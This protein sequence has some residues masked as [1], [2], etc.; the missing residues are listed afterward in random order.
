MH[1]TEIL[2]SSFIILQVEIN[3][4]VGGISHW[5]LCLCPHYLIFSDVLHGPWIRED[6]GDVIS[7]RREPLIQRRNVKSQKRGNVEYAAVQIAT[8]AHVYLRTDTSTTHV[9]N[10]DSRRR[11]SG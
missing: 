5:L 9:G 8:L 1:S 10:T 4:L 7:K 11:H 2:S 6:E 3:N